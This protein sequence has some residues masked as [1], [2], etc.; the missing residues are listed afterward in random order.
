MNAEK[1]HGRNAARILSFELG[2][3]SETLP[4]KPLG[5]HRHEGL[6]G[7]P[8]GELL[9]AGGQEQLDRLDA[10]DAGELV[11]EGGGGSLQRKLLLGRQFVEIRH[12]WPPREMVRQGQ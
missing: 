9:V 5:Q 1:Q 12:G 11:S 7:G 6:D 4:G 2:Q 10:E 3:G 8:S